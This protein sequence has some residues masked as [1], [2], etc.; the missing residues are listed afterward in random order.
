LLVVSCIVT[1]L[2]LRH[3]LGA[4][5]NSED[6]PGCELVLF[7]PMAHNWQGCRVCLLD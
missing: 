2:R 6:A 1:L 4:D 7:R 5:A 3:L